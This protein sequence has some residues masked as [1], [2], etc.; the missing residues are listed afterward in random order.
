M[1][2]KSDDLVSDII[3]L[4]Y[5]FEDLCEDQSTLRQLI[6]IAFDQTK[7]SQAKRLFEEIRAKTLFAEQQQDKTLLSQYLFEEICAKTLF[8]L[9]NPPGPFD[10]DSVSWVLP[11]ALKL[12]RAKGLSNISDINSLLKA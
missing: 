7:F 9:S 12:G 6:E 5:R 1:M 2:S 10:A 11:L 8:N 4:L 3:A